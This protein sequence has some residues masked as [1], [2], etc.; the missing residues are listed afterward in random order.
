MIAVMVPIAV[1]FWRIKLA[2]C[3]R[4]TA[5]VDRG[6]V[7]WHLPRGNPVNAHPDLPP[8][9]TTRAELARAGGYP[10]NACGHPHSWRSSL[11]LSSLTG[12]RM[13]LVMLHRAFPRGLTTILFTDIAGSTEVVVQLGDRR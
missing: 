13:L 11:E 6:A 10:T 1:A 2:D 7:L 5:C 9:R 3:R 8:S 4:E 12:G